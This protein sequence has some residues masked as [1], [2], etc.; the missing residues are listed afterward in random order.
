MIPPLAVLAT[1]RNVCSG[2]L[3]LEA[4]WAPQPD[5]LGRCFTVPHK[6][7]PSGQGQPTEE[8]R[9]FLG[10]PLP[11]WKVAAEAFGGEHP[12]A[13]LVPS[14]EPE[15]VPRAGYHPAAPL[16]HPAPPGPR[17]ASLL[18]FSLLL[19]RRWHANLQTLLLTSSYSLFPGRWGRT[20]PVLGASRPHS[21]RPAAGSCAPRGI[22]LAPVGI[23]TLTRA[24]FRNLAIRGDL[25][26]VFAT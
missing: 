1:D 21:S 23:S 3:W 17:G 20:L 8:A 19:E 7:P 6:K 5:H 13:L 18:L 15:A 25:Q 2:H 24:R 9:G 26:D 14:P 22:P 12:A 10:G 11:T 4:S 16:Q